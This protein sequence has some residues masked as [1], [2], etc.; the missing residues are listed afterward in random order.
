MAKLA[1]TVA[2]PLMFLGMRF[3]LAAVILVGFAFVTGRKRTDGG[4]R[5]PWL[6]LMGLGVVNFALYQG[7]A[8]LGMRS[9]SGGLATIITSLNPVLVSVLAAPILGESLGW[10]KCVGLLLGFAGAVFVVRNRVAIGEDLSGI[11]LLLIG[12]LSLTIGTLLTKRLAPGLDL[13]VMVGAQQAGAGLTLLLGSVLMGESVSQFVPGARLLL[14]T[15]WFVVVVSIASFLL[16][17]YLLRR[18]TAA[19][20]SSLHFLMPP[21]GL[22]MSWGLL[23][24]TLNPLDLLGV[25]PVAFGIWLATR[26]PVSSRRAKV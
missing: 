13:F 26:E 12:M 2:P 24:E 10:R 25:I 7:M 22:L 17:F 23:G 11:G 4:K 21:L 16:W 18:G 3:L 19:S 1:I 9:V 15:F 5:V 20:A 8:W 6:M 14:V